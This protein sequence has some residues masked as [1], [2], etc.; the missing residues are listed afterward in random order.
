MK[1]TG[2]SGTDR[3]LEDAQCF[4]HERLRFVRFAER[5]EDGRE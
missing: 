5:I 3:V 2:A 4:W 1:R